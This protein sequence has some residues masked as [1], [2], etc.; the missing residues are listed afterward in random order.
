VVPRTCTGIIIAAVTNVAGPTHPWFLLIAA[1]LVACGPAVE[2][3]DAESLE[4][5]C[6]EG[7]ALPPD[8]G[9]ACPIE[10]EVCGFADAGCSFSQHCENG[11]W[12]GDGGGCTPYEPPDPT[13]PPPPPT[14]DEISSAGDF[15]AFSLALS[16]PRRDGI[17]ALAPIPGSNDW[18][19]GGVVGEPAELGGVALSSTGAEQPFLARLS[20]DGSGIAARIIDGPSIVANVGRDGRVSHV[21]SGA[22]EEHAIA[23]ELW[24]TSSATGHALFVAGLASDLSERWSYPIGDGQS[25]D[26]IAGLSIDSAG[27]AIFAATV[28]GHVTLDASELAPLGGSDLVLAKLDADGQPIWAR[29]FGDAFDQRVDAMTLSANDE[30]I[31]AGTAS[32]AFSIGSHTVDPQAQDGVFVVQLDGD[33]ETMWRQSCGGDMHY[34]SDIDTGPNGVVWVTGFFGGKINC[35][36]LFM[37]SPDN[38]P[39]P[40]KHG[41]LLRLDAGG[42]VLS[43][44]DLGRFEKSFFVG[45]D[46]G[47]KLD[48]TD[49]GV[50][51]ATRLVSTTTIDGETFYPLGSSDTLLLE[52]TSQGSV[53]SGTFAGQKAEVRDLAV[54]ADGATFVAGR[55][56]AHLCWGATV[57]SNLDSDGASDGFLAKLLP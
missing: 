48:A 53:V 51:L 24:T 11:V 19:V 40:L 18:L 13:E 50:R 35:G 26:H 8:I 52:L 22:A 20:G 54:D 56:S 15:E 27:D 57:H 37:Q 30:V 28:E 33:G 17:E 43:L 47:P 4:G 1:W 45:N 3:N 31:F 12:V 21:A 49:G 34:V 23:G 10:G 39:V 25:W 38:G 46:E 5:A 32:S 16:T 6:P 36:G 55:F 44:L 9:S 29:R 7:F 2:R 41:F 42:K 14:C